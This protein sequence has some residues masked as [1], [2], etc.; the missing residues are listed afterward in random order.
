MMRHRLTIAVAVLVGCCLSAATAGK[1]TVALEIPFTPKYFSLG[2][3]DGDGK[4]DFLFKRA[5]NSGF[6]VGESK[7]VEIWAVRHDGTVLWSHTVGSAA[8]NNE[9][10]G[11]IHMNPMICYDVDG[12]GKWEVYT[13]DGPKIVNTYDEATKG[14]VEGKE[15]IYKLDPMTGKV[16]AQAAWPP[17]GDE[18]SASIRRNYLAIGYLDGKKPSVIATR[19]TYGHITAIAYDKELNRVWNKPFFRSSVANCGRHNT[20]TSDVDED[21]RDEIVLGMCVIDDDGSEMWCKGPTH[22]DALWV[23]D[24]DP[25]RKGMEMFVAQGEASK[26]VGV[27]DPATGKEV[28]MWPRS[29]MDGQ[30]IAG[31]FL[32]TAGFEFFVKADR[33][34]SPTAMLYE[35]DKVAAWVDVKGNV[36]EVGNCSTGGR[37]S[38]AYRTGDSYETCVGDEIFSFDGEGDWREETYKI[39]GK[40]IEITTPDGTPAITR[41]SLR[42]DRQYLTQSVIGRWMSGYPQQA[43][44]SVPIGY[45][46]GNEVGVSAPLPATALHNHSSAS[47][48]RL[49]LRGTA[50]T[51]ITLAVDKAGTVFDIRGRIVEPLHTQRTR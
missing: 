46:P 3:F 20:L 10:D 6:K 49:V 12:D 51:G 8:P 19:G 13:K 23:G 35:I 31:D 7:F 11:W 48:A 27:V 16:L 45:K 37:P 41:L 34:Y 44:P 26:G 47:P 40:T 33:E 15:Y 50:G 4:F 32:P 38:A 1:R 2:D 18:V 14:S 24:L 30:G 43:L 17:L 29:T 22:A 21:G 25:E 36:V 42:T 9:G 39:V 28:W 5:K